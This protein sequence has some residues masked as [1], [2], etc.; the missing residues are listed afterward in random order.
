MQ[1][2]LS[3]ITTQMSFEAML[4]RFPVSPSQDG[5]VIGFA[6]LADELRVY[7]ILLVW[8]CLRAGLPRL[9]FHFG[10]EDVTLVL[11]VRAITV[12]GRCRS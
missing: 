9:P 10:E 2:V 5:V 3:Q 1:D 6:H 7:R 12:S 8:M 11:V 4:R